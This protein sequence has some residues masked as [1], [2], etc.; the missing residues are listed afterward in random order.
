MHQNS[1]T[2][3]CHSVNSDNK[4]NQEDNARDIK[5]VR[6]PMSAITGK[7]GFS[8]KR[9]LSKV[10]LKIKSTFTPSSSA[11]HNGASTSA[12]QSSTF[13]CSPNESDS[14]SPESVDQDPT[15][16]VKSPVLAR[17]PYLEKR[18]LESI[19]SAEGVDE[20]D[21]QDEG[22]INDST[23][24]VRPA[25][26]PLFE[27][28]DKLMDMKRI[29]K[30][31]H[32]KA[33]LLSVPNSKSQKHE[34]IMNN[35]KNDDNTSESFAGNL[36]RRFNKFDSSFQRSR[37]SSMSSL[38]NISTETISCLT[39]A[40]SYT[41][42]SDGVSFKLKGCILTMSFLDC[43][44]ALIPNAFE[45]WKD[46]SVDGKSSKS[47]SINSSRMSPL[48]NAQAV[49][50]AEGFEDQQFL[51][52]TS[53]K[54]A[55]V[56]ALPSQNIVYRQQLSETHAVIKAEITTLKDSVCLMCY[57]S[58]GHVATYSLPSLRPLIDVD[59]LPLQDL[60]FQTT[61]HGIVDPMLSIWGHQLFV[62]GD[63]DQ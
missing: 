19:L 48:L 1:Q 6:K 12:K 30:T 46:D 57:V 41:K 51:V 62:N 34:T 58:N 18:P 53:E 25:D 15:L 24:A 2:Q 61:K 39:F 33:R 4:E 55:K 40:D 26:L 9:Q 43:N 49:G 59:F 31:R 5:D 20:D 28:D 21:N 23:R 42:K 11:S 38:E 44:G 17:S 7:K 45:S 63:T 8:L 3:D 10:D 47:K 36:M 37:S 32:S 54:Q 56:V 14:A 52:L 27:N 13:Y 60:S 29:V 50:G 22:K 35:Q 16:C